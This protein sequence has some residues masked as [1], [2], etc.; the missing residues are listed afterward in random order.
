MAIPFC[1]DLIVRAT[2][3]RWPSSVSKI[4]PCGR[5]PPV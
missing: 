4:G 2:M 3:N 1:G 5:D